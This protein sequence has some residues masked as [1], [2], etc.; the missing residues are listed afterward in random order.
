METSSV[1]AIVAAVAATITSFVA[2]GTVIY[3]AGVKV[4]KLEVKVETLWEFQIRRGMAE[5]VHKGVAEMNSPLTFN[6]EVQKYL[7]PL[8]DQLITFWDVKGKSLP[9]TEALLELEREFGDALLRDV[10]IPG[11]LSHGACL[12]LAYSVASQQR[13]ISFDIGRGH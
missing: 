3:F 5:A 10:C 13:Q 7:E 11:G 9:P 6:E 1:I 2:L 8:K 12:L 4:S